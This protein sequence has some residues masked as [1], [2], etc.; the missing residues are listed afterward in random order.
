[1]PQPLL[2]T[3][4]NIRSVTMKNRIVVAPMQQV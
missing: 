4:L 3:P 1:M 2:F